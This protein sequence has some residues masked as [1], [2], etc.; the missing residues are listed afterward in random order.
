MI[1]KYPN[2]S[3]EE[4]KN[5]IH[6]SAK[7]FKNLINQTSFAT[8]NDESRPQL[9]GIN[10]KINGGELECNATDSYRLARKCIKLDKENNNAY[11]II[12]PSRNI[13][14]YTKII[15]D[16]DEVGIHIFNSKV[17]FK[18]TNLLFQSRLINGS[19]PNT[20]NLLPQNS[21]LKIT[22]NINDLY[23]VIDR[24]S[25]LTSDKEKNIVNLET[26]G[27]TLIM[28]SSSVEIGRKY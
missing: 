5:P 4:N 23:N 18:T 21:L 28:R 7:V 25:I 13:T 22:V 19:Y 20:A 12:I 6:I 15:S 1:W 26:D 3:L 10:I 14:E 24:V 11:N 16:D 27:N 17:L 8:S 9:T 2:I